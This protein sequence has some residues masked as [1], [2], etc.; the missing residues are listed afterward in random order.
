M[1]SG[2]FR[3]RAS[4]QVGAYFGLTPSRYQSG[5][6]DVP[7]RISKIGD[8]GVRTVLYEAANVML[9]RPVKGSALKD[10]A[11]AVARR[12][13]GFGMDVLASSRRSGVPLEELLEHSIVV[14]RGTSYV[15]H[16]REL[17][18]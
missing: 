5:E 16:L 17:V 13:E 3:F 8:H 15:R 18:P 10:W 6:T 9:T 11:V 1:G 4:R 12:A 7:G 2:H 14:P